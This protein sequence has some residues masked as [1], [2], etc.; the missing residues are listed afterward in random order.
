MLKLPAFWRFCVNSYVIQISKEHSMYESGYDIYIGQDL[1]FTIRILGWYITQQHDI[2]NSYAKSMN[3]ITVSDLIKKVSNYKLCEGTKNQ[4]I[5]HLA[6]KHS[7]D[8]KYNPDI[9]YSG[10]IKLTWKQL[11][12]HQF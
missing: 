10:T 5:Q 8:L 3:N 9:E 4:Q 2:Y 11:S 6:L 12:L 1:S 7:V